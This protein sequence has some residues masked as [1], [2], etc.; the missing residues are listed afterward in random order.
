MSWNQFA[1]IFGQLVVYF[2]NFM[3]LGDHANPII[4]KTAENIYNIVNLSGRRLTIDRGW[5][6]MFGSGGYRGRP[7]HSAGMLRA[8]VAALPLRL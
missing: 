6:Y 2:V 1:I 5:R 4:E 8:R 7:V 3:I